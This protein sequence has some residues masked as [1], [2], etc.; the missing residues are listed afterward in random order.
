VGAVYRAWDDAARREVA[1]KVLNARFAADPRTIEP[2]RRDPAAC[3]RLRHP[4]LVDLLEAGPDHLVAELVEGESLA[5]WLGRGPVG[6]EEALALLGAV[7][8]GVDHVHACGLVHGDVKPSNVL[9]PRAGC[10]RLADLGIAVRGW[11][12]LRRGGVVVGSPA[13]M[14]PERLSRDLVHPAGD[15]YALAAVAYETL[16]GVL[17]LRRASLGALLL[18]IV[19]DEPPPASALNPSLP[20]AVD[21]VLAKGLAKA[22]EKRYAVGRALVA[23]LRNALPR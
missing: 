14:A 17:P 16:T 9:L 20:A 22:P 4:A 2:F 19:A 18:S 7:A 10:A 12:P 11:L 8:A 13:Y 21:A 1:V 5:A 6:P 23:A 15:L 3:R